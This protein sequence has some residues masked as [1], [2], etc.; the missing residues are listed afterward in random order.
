MM[1][2]AA[3]S[4]A[5]AAAGTNVMEAASPMR[6]AYRNFVLD[7]IAVMAAGAAHPSISSARQAFVMTGGS[8]SLLPWESQSLVR[9]AL[10][11]SSMEWR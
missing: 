6:A 9:R 2:S 3:T 1:Q 10:R 5:L 11:V 4:L 8:E 7:T